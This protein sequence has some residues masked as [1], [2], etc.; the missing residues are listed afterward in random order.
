MLIMTRLDVVDHAFVWLLWKLPGKVMRHMDKR[1]LYKDTTKWTIAVF[2][3]SQPEHG[4]T[5]RVSRAG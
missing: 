1:M 3:T 4:A 5:A 2:S